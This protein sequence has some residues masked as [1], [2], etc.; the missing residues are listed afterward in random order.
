LE[1]EK[2]GGVVPHPQSYDVT[3]AREGRALKSTRVVDVDAKR[4]GKQKTGGTIGVPEGV[5]PWRRYS[6]RK[7]FVFVGVFCTRMV[8][9]NL[10]EP[11]RGGWGC[12]C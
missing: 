1:R 4:E 5:K 9:P 8:V 3:V 10:G 6:G 12:P 7:L 11:T 2:K